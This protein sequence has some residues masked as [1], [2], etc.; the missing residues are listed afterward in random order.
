SI[1]IPAMKNIHFDFETACELDLGKAGLHRYIEHPSFKPLCVSWKTSVG[2]PVVTRM[3]DGGG[4]PLELHAALQDEKVQG[5]AW[6]AAFEEQILEARYGF[7]PARRL[8]C[9]MQ[10]AYAYGLPGK[11]ERAGPALGCRWTKDMAGHRLMKK[12]SKDPKGVWTE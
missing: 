12:M 10:R 1:I 9:T 8:S 5:H 7:R 11:L 4:L 6:N 2:N 3:D